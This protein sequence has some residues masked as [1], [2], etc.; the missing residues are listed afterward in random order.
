[1]ALALIATGL[2]AKRN[3]DVPARFTSRAAGTHAQ[4]ASGGTHEAA[5]LRARQFGTI[6]RDHGIFLFP[7]THAHFLGEKPQ[8][9]YSVCFAAREL[10]GAQAGEKDSLYVDM[11]DDYLEPA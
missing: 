9:V 7:D 5:A 2:P 1:M 6:D 4:H 11:W 3:V 8:H 10:W